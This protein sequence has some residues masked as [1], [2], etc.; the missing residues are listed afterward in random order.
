MRPA[1]HCFCHQIQSF[2]PK[3]KFVILIHPIEHRRRIA[4]GRMSHLCLQNSHFILGDDYTNDVRVNQIIDDP[5]HSCFILYPGA[6]ALDLNHDCIPNSV[7]QKKIVIFVIDGTWRTAG[8]SIRFSKNLCK[9]PKVCFTPKKKSAFRVRKQPKPE[10]YSTVEAIHETI[11]L[12]GPSVGFDVASRKHDNL[13]TV[14]NW[15]V[16]KQIASY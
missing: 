10:F 2:D 1:G 6:D 14:F 9:L 13:L 5:N 7:G 8:Q 12:L 11:E 3:I 16:D 4:T 15:M